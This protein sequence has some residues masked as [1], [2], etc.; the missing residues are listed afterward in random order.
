LSCYFGA[1]HDLRPGAID[2]EPEVEF[3]VFWGSLIH[4]TNDSPYIFLTRG[5]FTW[6][7]VGNNNLVVRGGSPF[8][9]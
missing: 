7:K 9:H 5:S 4:S 6:L 2:P 3:A 1:F 8:A